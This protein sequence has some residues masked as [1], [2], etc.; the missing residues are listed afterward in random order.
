MTIIKNQADNKSPTIL[1]NI[2]KRIAVFIENII[3][4]AL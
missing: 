4:F 2:L 3:I 1:L